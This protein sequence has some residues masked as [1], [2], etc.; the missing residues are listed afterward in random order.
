MNVPKG[1]VL[2]DAAC[3]LAGA[4][5]PLAFAPWG[6]YPV[7]IAGLAVL[8]HAWTRATPGRA[9]LRGYL[10]GLGMFGVGVNWLHISINLFGG[11]NLVLALAA[12]FA[13]VAFLAL[14]PA[15]TGYLARRLP[16]PGGVALSAG[17]MPALWVLVEWV[18]TWLLTGFPWLH[19]GYSQTDSVLGGFAPLGGVF[20]TS[21][22][23]AFIAGAVAAF[24]DARRGARI[25][26]G[27]AVLA[28]IAAGW[29][30]RQQAW[31]EPGG[32]TLSVALI[33]GAVPQEVKW[34]EGYRDHSV[35]RYMDLTRESWDADIIVW[36]ETAIPA[37]KDQLEE[38]LGPLAERAAT[39]EA[40]LY[41]GLPVRDS[42]SREYFNALVY[43]G[44][45]AQA[46][47]KRHLVP[48]G[49]YLPM[50]RWL[51]PMFAFL[52]I[53][54][55]AFSAGRQEEPLL[56]G[57]H[58]TVGVSICYEDAFGEE[59]IQALPEAGLLIN[60]SNDAWFGDSIARHQHLQMARLRALESGRYLLRATNTGL[61]AIIDEKGRIVATGPAD[62]PVA[63][64]GTARTF[65][66]TT[67]YAAMGNMPVIIA[68]ALVVAALAATRKRVTSK[69]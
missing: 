38:L 29:L 10:F 66:G 18:R 39:E 33:Q 21:W 34:R 59:V 31:T 45:P 46:Y 62:E 47:H 65:T 49:E 19:A 24:P 5:F 1:T 12:T 25:A 50:R 55:S 41:I 61:T 43:I 26:L 63:V 30:A 13:L 44:E 2:P 23:A 69:N 36:P 8:F 32:E 67:P 15:V 53:P 37:F 40:D 54:M 51:G 28:V 60:V 14:Y 58:G 22:A 17:A 57:R 20:L 64:R 9:F 68:A 3:L 35:L 56:R 48:F 11:V 27:A 4:L 52:Q 16:L 7:A 42:G 6:F